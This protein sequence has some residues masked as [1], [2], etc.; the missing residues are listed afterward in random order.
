M[1]TMRDKVNKKV[2]YVI[3][4]AGPSRI[5]QLIL[6]SMD[7]TRIP[8]ETGRDEYEYMI[9]DFVPLMRKTLIDA[10]QLSTLSGVE[11]MENTFL[12]GLN[13]HLFDIGIDFSVDEHTEG[14]CAIGSGME[15]ALGV[16]HYL[17]NS[18][19]SSKRKIQRALEAASYYNNTVGKPF[20]FE[21]V[22][23]IENKSNCIGFDLDSILERANKKMAEG[24]KDD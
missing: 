18:A 3:A 17:R 5:S 4:G 16:L 22:K 1:R 19:L 7:L 15:Y 9:N 6:Y 8:F 12:I 11:E 21:S 24:E 20:V 23:L 14:Y 10:G 13:G 2:P